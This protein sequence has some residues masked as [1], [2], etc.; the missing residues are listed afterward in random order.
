MKR[1]KLR[2]FKDSHYIKCKSIP[3]DLKDAIEKK[4]L[5]SNSYKEPLQ[6]ISES[7]LRLSETK[8]FLIRMKAFEVSR[9]L[10]N[11]L[12]EC[13]YIRGM[14]KKLEDYI[15][16]DLI[17]PDCDDKALPKTL[18]TDFVDLYITAMQDPM[19]FPNEK[20]RKLNQLINKIIT[21]LAFNKTEKHDQI[22]QH[23]LD[24]D[25][26]GDFDFNR[27]F[28]TQNQDSFRSYSNLNNNLNLMSSGT[29]I[30][31]KRKLS[32]L[33]KNNS[34]PNDNVVKHEVIQ[35]EEIKE[36][37]KSKK[38]KITKNSSTKSKKLFQTKGAKYEEIK[39]TSIQSE[40]SAFPS[41]L[42]KSKQDL[43]DTTD[44]QV[45][46]DWLMTNDRNYDSEN[47]EIPLVSS[48]KTHQKKKSNLSNILIG[49]PLKGTSIANKTSPSNSIHLSTVSSNPVGN[50][51]ITNSMDFRG[52]ENEGFNRS[53]T[54]FD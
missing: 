16:D 46:S 49:A 7:H 31:E 32:R 43:N 1:I 25:Y 39:D 14:S 19:S 34:T 9:N 36:N 17:H 30:F 50:L 10:E 5:T 53:E 37:S 42:R 27:Y 35:L 13:G 6:L 47:E 15:T 52:N 4:H 29:N 26:H 11:A 23:K 18:L 45:N 51:Q 22:I 33:R 20:L 54:V 12:A 44:S 8:N 48:K 40:N 41:F 2:N 28:A 38:A 21:I 3:Q 24:L